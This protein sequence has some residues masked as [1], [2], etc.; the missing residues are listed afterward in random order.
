MS[1]NTFREIITWNTGRRYS[2]AG[3]RI[4]AGICV[5]DH[6]IHFADVDRMIVGV[7]NSDTIDLDADAVL[8]EYDH[9]RYEGTTISEEETLWHAGK[10]WS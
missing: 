9:N 6:K 5:E 1:K 7:L 8:R 2:S 3:Q 10:E 4:A